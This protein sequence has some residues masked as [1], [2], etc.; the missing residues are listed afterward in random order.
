MSDLCVILIN[1][2]QKE[3]KEVNQ[4]IG[5]YPLPITGCD[6]LLNDLPKRRSEL[7]RKM[8]EMKVNP[9][10]SMWQGGNIY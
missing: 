9:E 1:S 3:F 2:I 7:E 6:V 8:R 5:Y 4:V 10:I